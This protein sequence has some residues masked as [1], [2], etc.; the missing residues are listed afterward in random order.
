MFASL[1]SIAREV[2]LLPIGHLE[3]GLSPFADIWQRQILNNEDL[4]KFR[5][6][7]W[8]QKTI[9]PNTK[10]RLWLIE[11]PKC[12]FIDLEKEFCNEETGLCDTFDAKRKLAYFM[13]DFHH[14]ALGSL[15]VGQR[16]RELYDEWVEKQKN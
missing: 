1:A 7:L 3:S 6:P 15:K 13:D 4:N 8:Y 11:C 2:I 9:C 14:N 12:I 16:V 10:Q 5:S